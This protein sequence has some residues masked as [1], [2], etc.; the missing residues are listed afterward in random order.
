MLEKFHDRTATGV[1]RVVLA[2]TVLR[3]GKQ[4]EKLPHY[5]FP[6]QPLS[7]TEANARFFSWRQD[8]PEGNYSPLQISKRVFSKEVKNSRRMCNI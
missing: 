7:K 4:M 1:T 2:A 3:C 8:N 5:K 6:A